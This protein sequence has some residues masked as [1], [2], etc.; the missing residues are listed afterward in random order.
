[1]VL[2]VT[3]VQKGG[4]GNGLRIKTM[5]SVVDMVS[6]M[7]LLDIQVE[8]SETQRH[9]ISRKIG[10]GKLELGTIS[11]QMIIEFMGVDQITQ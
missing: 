5:S 10:A 11:I 4:V 9:K 7:C 8:I 1:M 2:F 6:F 3:G